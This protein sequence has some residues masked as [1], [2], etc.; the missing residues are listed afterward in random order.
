MEVLPSKVIVSIKEAPKAVSPIVSTV[1]G[2]TMFLMP[3]FW[4]ALSA[5]VLTVEEI[6]T[7]SRA[8]VDLNAR[9]S[10]VSRPSLRTTFL[11]DV[12]ESNARPRVVTVSGRIT[13]SMSV[14]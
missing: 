5:I 1:A 3:D 2:I 8:V 12:E 6:I 4:K 7:S 11:T 10:I 9:E 14:L 13:F